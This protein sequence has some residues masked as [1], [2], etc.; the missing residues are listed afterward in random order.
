M[1]LKTK[2]PNQTF[3]DF[4]YCYLTKIILFNINH[5]FAQSKVTS[6]IVH[7]NSLIYTH[8]NDSK[9]CYLTR[10]ILLNTIH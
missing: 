5:L 7:T 8:L 10:I 9:Y 2:K 6:S 3:N 1:P 4:K